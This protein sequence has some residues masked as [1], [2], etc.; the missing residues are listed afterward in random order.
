MNRT[1][2]TA[3]QLEFLDWE[4]GMVFPFWAADLLS[5]SCGLGQPSDGS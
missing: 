4:I 3:K 1:L 5:R 2:P